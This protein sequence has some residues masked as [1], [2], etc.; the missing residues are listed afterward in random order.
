IK[1]F[2]VA[3]AVA[4]ILTFVCNQEGSAFPFL[5]ENYVSAVAAHWQSAGSFG[6]SI[7]LQRA[8]VAKCCGCIVT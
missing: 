1:T 7:Y 4:A 8:S 6:P 3:A 2:R 5:G